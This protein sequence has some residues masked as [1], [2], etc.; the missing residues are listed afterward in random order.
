M[1][2]GRQVGDAASWHWDELL[3]VEAGQVRGLPRWARWLIDLGDW[4]A[5][6]SPAEGVARAVV[7]V[8]T[9]R[10]A[11]VLAAAGIVTGAARRAALRDP[12]EQ[13][14]RLA[15]LPRNTPVRYRE[16]NSNKASSGR[17]EGIVPE[18]GEDH[19]RLIGGYGRAASQC[20]YIEPLPEGCDP[21]LGVREICKHLDFV[22]SLS[23]QDA[24]LHAFPQQVE[25]TIVG[26]K[27]TIREEFGLPLRV[28]NHE[29]TLEDVVRPAEM[30]QHPA[31]GYRSRIVSA[32]TDPK[33][34][35]RGDTQGAVV[36]DGASAI[37]R[38]RYA[39][40][41]RPWLAV[42]D[43]TSSSADPAVSALLAERATGIADLSP[44]VSEA[45]P[46]IE[47]LCYVEAEP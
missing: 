42:L 43:R 46:G 38:W 39:V 27:S 35:R 36:L 32:V 16:G 33:T 41:A 37:L 47:T 2:P 1:L 20:A 13:L 6:Y 28:E 11:G 5:S 45:P 9:R 22:G 26:T 14:A 29:G 8:P 17:F 44:T 18:R 23:G 25:C 30:Q 4:L 21:F 3:Y 12:A 31:D 15:A 40:R 19:V 10:F 34:I 24:V 7:S